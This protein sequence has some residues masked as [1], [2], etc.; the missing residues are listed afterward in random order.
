M[1]LVSQTASNQSHGAD[2]NS[3]RASVMHAQKMSMFSKKMPDFRSAK[4]KIAQMSRLEEIQHVHA[5]GPC[6]Y[7]K[8]SQGYLTTRKKVENTRIL[9]MQACTRALW[10][11]MALRW[12]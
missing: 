8:Y 6:P 2:R 3:S 4:E 11:D 9:K 5:A 12:R 7:E 1:V 10:H